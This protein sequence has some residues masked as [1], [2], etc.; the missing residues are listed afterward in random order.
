MALQLR[1]IVS[2]LWTSAQ[3]I[4]PE[5]QTRKKLR[6]EKRW[7]KSGDAA[8]TIVMTR[9]KENSLKE[10]EGLQ[11]MLPFAP[12]ATSDR[13]GWK[14]LQAARYRKNVA[15]G[16]FSGSAT[17]H[18]LVLTIQPAEKMDVSMLL[19]DSHARWLHGL[20]GC[21]RPGDETVRHQ[22]MTPPSLKLK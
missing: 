1:E 21:R 11:R 3:K 19:D 15:N 9:L 10:L 16:E 4:R 7:L 20:I 18:M 13:R 5:P 14:G 6:P 12:F 17:M 2:R 22:E 8:G